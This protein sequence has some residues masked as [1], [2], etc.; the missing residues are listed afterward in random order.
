M[1]NATRSRWMKPLLTLALILALPLPAFSW[2][3]GGHM[4]TAR[5]AYTRLNRNAQAEV[6]R[7]IKIKIN[8]ENV[9]ADSLNFV[10]ASHWADDLKSLP[11]FDFLKELH[12]I[13]FPFSPDGTPLPPN[14]PGEKNI[15]T[16]LNEN[17]DILK[18]STDDTE[19]ARALRLIIHFVGDLH[20]PLHC[21]ARVTTE[22]PKGDQG[23]NLFKIRGSSSN[24]HSYW[25]GGIGT[26]PKG[27]PA[28][29]FTPP[30]VSQI[31]PAAARIARKFPATI[32]AWRNGG[33]A[34]FERWAKESSTLARNTA[35]KNIRQHQV[36][37]R[38]YNQAALRVAE[39]RVAWGGYRLAAL[40][41]S[42][43]PA[44]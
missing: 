14:L 44:R 19:R 6:D 24:L 1:T 17:L 21:A 29:K 42:I 2:G 11:Q 7:L 28:P 26:F 3:P 40:L 31:L 20:Q 18:N 37:S 27:G 4:M 13:D 5:I 33:P 10:D 43:W 25:D 23:G 9:T 8:P 36:P 22:N 12:F 32:G 15:L 35:Y 30:P 38:R 39:R 34:D 16:A 41:N